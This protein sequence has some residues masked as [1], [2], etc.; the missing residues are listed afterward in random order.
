MKNY[1]VTISETIVQQ[2]IFTT[3]AI[4]PEEAEDLARMRFECNYNPNDFKVLD[5]EGGV[6]YDVEEIQ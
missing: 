2:A 5:N 3:K 1:K 4:S 6:D